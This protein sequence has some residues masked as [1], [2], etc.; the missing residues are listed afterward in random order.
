LDRD[1]G[2]DGADAAEFIQDFAAEFHV[3]ASRF[4]FDKYF[5]PEAVDPMFEFRRLVKRRFRA[6][7]PLRVADLAKA[8]QSRTLEGC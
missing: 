1:L 2:L 3:D 6:R 5:G 4:E 8:I 7:R